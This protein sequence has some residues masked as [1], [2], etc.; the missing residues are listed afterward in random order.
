MWPMKSRPID[1]ARPPQQERPAPG[2]RL[3]L[4]VFVIL[5]AAAFG[6]LWLPFIVRLG[7]G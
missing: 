7:G 4:A 3:I 2:E 6:L 1:Y 5:F